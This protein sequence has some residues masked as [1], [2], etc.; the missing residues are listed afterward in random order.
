MAINRAAMSANASPGFFSPKNNGD[1]AAFR[2][3]CI[4]NATKGC[5]TRLVLRFCHTSQAAT[6]IQMYSPVQT[7][8]N[9]QPGGVNQGLSSWLYHS[10][11]IGPDK[12]CPAKATRKH[13]PTKTGTNNKSVLCLF[14][15]VANAPFS[16]HLDS[17]P[18]TC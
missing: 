9:I 11:G 4:E 13:K 16:L 18:T 15:V 8:A 3:S 6:P 7:G 1:Q 5:I 10:F 17:S 14:L 12:N 2:S